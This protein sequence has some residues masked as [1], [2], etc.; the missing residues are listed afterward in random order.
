MTDEEKEK[1]YEEELSKITTDPHERERTENVLRILLKEKDGRKIDFDSRIKQ[2]GILR[3][4]GQHF[5]AVDA[6]EMLALST[7]RFRKLRPSSS[8]V[9]R[10]LSLQL[11][12][13]QGSEA[14]LRESKLLLRFLEKEIR[15]D[16]K[17]QET[18]NEARKFIDDLGQEPVFRS[19]A[20]RAYQ[21]SIIW[22]ELDH[23]VNI[24][25]DELWKIFCDQ[26]PELL[27]NVQDERKAKSLA[28]KDAK[29]SFLK[30]NEGGKPDY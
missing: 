11:S 21:L 18:L 2:L 29:L 26:H 7:D 14:S 9:I 27:D 30:A 20:K 3:I 12:L 1:L 5:E 22:R 25:R 16:L 6:P 23:P 17:A 19:R 10:E 15:G 13:I 28:F 8:P 24:H 4:L